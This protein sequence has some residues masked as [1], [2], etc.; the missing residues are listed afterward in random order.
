MTTARTRL[1]GAMARLGAALSLNGL[2]RDGLTASVE[3]ICRQSLALPV[4]CVTLEA[5]LA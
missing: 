2:A 3:A 4:P 5:R 1:R